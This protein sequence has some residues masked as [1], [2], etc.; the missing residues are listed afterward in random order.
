MNWDAIGALAEL[1]G[2]LGVIISLLYLAGQIRNAN[3]AA[4]VAA[5]LDST[6]F[7]TDYLDLLIQNPEIADLINRGR[8]DQESLSKDEFLRFSNC[9]LKAFYYFSAGYFQN[10]LGTLTDASFR[11]QLG[12]IDYWLRGSAVRSW[13]TAFGRDMFEQDFVHF[14]DERFEIVAARQRASQ[15]GSSD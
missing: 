12:I 5:K 9:A 8:R 11:E 2:A 7:I 6:R 14:I 15:Q 10:R 3:R 13:W 4:A 1:L